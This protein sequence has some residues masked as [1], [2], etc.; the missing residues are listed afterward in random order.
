MSK[1]KNLIMDGIDRV[2]YSGTND[3]VQVYIKKRGFVRYISIVSP[4]EGI[5]DVMKIFIIPFTNRCIIRDVW[6]HSIKLDINMYVVRNKI[7]PC[8]LNGIEDLILERFQK[9]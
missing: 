7:I 8:N 5:S 6:I 3:K 2:L 9:G 1:I 4:Y